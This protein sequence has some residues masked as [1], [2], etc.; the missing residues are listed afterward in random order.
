[1]EDSVVFKGLFLKI[2]TCF[3]AVQVS[4]VGKPQLNMV[5]FQTEKH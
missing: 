5:S 4:L 3:P 1:M 2:P